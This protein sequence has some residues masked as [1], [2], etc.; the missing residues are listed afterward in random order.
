MKCNCKTSGM[1]ALTLGI[2]AGFAFLVGLGMAFGVSDADGICL[3][4]LPKTH[5]TARLAAERSW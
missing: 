3:Q 2:G 4:H 1:S 5:T